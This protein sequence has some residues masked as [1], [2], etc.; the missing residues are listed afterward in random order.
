[1]AQQPRLRN[2][3]IGVRTAIVNFAANPRSATSARRLA[4]A[5]LLVAITAVPVQAASPAGLEVI[6]PWSRPAAASGTAA[7]FM[8]LTNHSRSGDALVAVASPLARK[9]EMHRSVLAG[10]VMSMR[11]QP[12]VDLPAGGAVRFSPGGHHLM[13]LGLT[14]PLKAGDS[15]PAT[16]TF[17]SGAT[18]NVAFAVGT[19]SGPTA[20]GH[21]H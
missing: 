7:G 4:F 8:D 21:R 19:G 6:R 14:R 2:L 13:F 1:M 20:P 16:L 9:V 10:G 17:A 3:R 11:R 15:L 5:V 12:R 18:L